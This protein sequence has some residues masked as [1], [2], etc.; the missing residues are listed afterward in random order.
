MNGARLIRKLV[1]LA[2]EE[3]LSFGDITAQL[4]VPEAHRSIATV[5]AKEP[6]VFCGSELFAPLIQ[7]GKWS[8]KSTLTVADGDNL[9]NGSTI[10]SLEGF[11]RDLLAMERTLLNFLQRLSGV[12]TKTASFCRAEPGLIILDTRKTMP[13]WRVLDKYAVR[14]GGG[15]NH[16]FCLG[17][18]VLVKNNHVDVYA[19]GMAAVLEK[20]V[21][22]K[23]LYMPWEVE[24]RDL[25]ELETAL[26]FNPTIIMLDNFSDEHVARAVEIVR[27]AE[28]PPMIE[29][30]GGITIERLAKL[31]S[32]GIDAISVGALT[33]QA[34]NVDIAMK[35]RSACG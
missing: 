2:L 1:S 27:R 9:V 12:A 11:T 17:D 34:K 20:I 25:S 15:R 16:R 24:V 32:C 10:A 23:P 28:S 19:Q 18:M 33:T 14:V 21:A 4:T 3:D 8:I 29:V 35:I 13:G 26:S 7:E 22:D 30:S 6:M 31:A 5:Y